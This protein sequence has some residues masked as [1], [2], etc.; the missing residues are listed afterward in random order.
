MDRH[1]EIFERHRGALSAAAQRIVGT[2]TEVDDVMQ[3]AWLSWSGVDLDEIRDPRAYLFRLVGR[4]SLDQIRRSRRAWGN[5]RDVP[6]TE[7]VVADTVQDLELAESVSAA[8]LVMLETL[9]PAERTVFLL[10]EVFGFSH[11][12]IAAIVGR[13]ER[14]VRQVAYRARGRLHTRQP[15]YRPTHDEH[16]EVTERFLAALNGVGNLAAHARTCEA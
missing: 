7:P 1:A 16:R 13:T 11:A 15:R 8:L 10:R 4:Q 9:A 6:G 12:E 3:E 5:V 2:R 14:A